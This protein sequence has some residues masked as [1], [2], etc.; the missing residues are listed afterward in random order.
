MSDSKREQRKD[1]H[2]KI[3]VAQSDA[4]LTDFDRIRF[5]HHS[6]PSVDVD[7]VDLSVELP[8]FKL[9]SPLY[10]NAMTG[11]SEWT[12]QINEKLAIVAKET[13]LA[14][15]VG[16]THAALRNPKMES[17]FTVAREMNPD[18]IIFS[19]V[20]ADVPADL[21]KQSV[22]ML[23]ADALQVHVNA[24][25]EL[26]M[27]EGNRTFSNWMDNL[28]RI[29][30]TV[31]VPV[32]VKEVGFGMSRETM[33]AL[34][35]IGVH[36]VDVSGRGGTNFVS[37]ENERRDLKDMSYLQN[38]GQSTVESLLESKIVQS[39][40]SVFASGGVRNPFD[41]IKCLALGADA[42]GMSRPFLEQVE[43]NGVEQ[44]IEYVEAFIEQM[45]KIAVMAN[46]PNIEAIHNLEVIY[47]QSLQNWIQQRN[48]NQ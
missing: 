1:D 34:N 40:M 19:N 10:I 16:S 21:A 30:K 6:I 44:T 39:H 31:D 48:L 36:Y 32:I 18:G 4:Q 41:A 15:A 42:V 35:E 47:D 23:K 45:K 9:N 29:V 25:Q 17:T 8:D 46:V 13:G 11:G 7:Q 37:I 5:V 26:V 38:W 27:P 20:G 33:E 3:A 28:N 2:V 43:N 14:M 24:P 12:K 22:E